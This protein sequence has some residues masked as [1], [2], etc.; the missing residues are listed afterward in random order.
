MTWSGKGT[1]LA[2]RWPPPIAGFPFL[3][4]S[5][6]SKGWVVALSPA[7][8]DPAGCLCSQ[9]LALQPVRGASLKHP[10]RLAIRGLLPTSRSPEGCGCRKRRAR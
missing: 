10:V 1:S 6:F 4:P 3:L 8:E 9:L 7:E 2:L 5:W